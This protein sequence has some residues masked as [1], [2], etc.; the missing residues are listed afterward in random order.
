MINLLPTIEKEKLLQE[1]NW[2]LVLILG[3]S[4]LFFLV[5]LTL[6]LFAIKIHISSQLESQKLF[7][8]EKEKEFQETE[9]YSFRT[10][11]QE[12]NQTL[13]NVGFFFQQ[14]DS[15]VDLFEKICRLLPKGILLNNFSHKFINDS[16]EFKA[17][18]FLTG[19]ASTQKDLLEFKESLEK[20]ES[21]AD[22]SL[23]LSSWM[24][25]SDID[26]SLNFKIIK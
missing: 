4:T 14:Q 20:E 18:I 12:V 11:I 24:E 5:S 17:D 26:F 16:E 1:K 25:F 6:V 3:V 15:F 22:P 2:R 19:V 8:T 7:F 9:L 13:T 10:K 23:P 21:F